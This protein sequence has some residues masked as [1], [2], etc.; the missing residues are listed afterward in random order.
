MQ[1]KAAEQAAARDAEEARTAKFRPVGYEHL[2][3][4][5]GDTVR[6]VGRIEEWRRGKADGSGEWVRQVVVA[7]GSGGSIGERA[8][9]IAAS[10]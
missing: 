5:V 4:R 7:D 1:R 8:L 2:D 10:V 3:I 6:V 9:A